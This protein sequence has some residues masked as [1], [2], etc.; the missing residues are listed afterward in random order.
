MRN[1][2]TFLK[3]YPLVVVG[4][5]SCWLL[6]GDA[7]SALAAC[8]GKGV[9]CATSSQCCSAPDLACSPISGDCELATYSGICTT[10]ADCVSS[11]CGASGQCLPNSSANGPCVSDLDCG[12]DNLYQLACT[13][14]S[15]LYP[16]GGH[17]CTNDNNCLSNDCVTGVPNTCSC[18]A[19]GTFC[20]SSAN[21]CS[22]ECAGGKCLL[23]SGATCAGGPDCASGTCGGTCACSNLGQACG[24]NGDCATCTANSECVHGV[25]ALKQGTTGCAGKLCVGDLPSLAAGTTCVGGQCSAA[26]SVFNW[27]D[28]NTDCGTNQS[29]YTLENLGWRDG[30]CLITTAQA[31]ANAVSSD[32]CLSNN[33]AGTPSKCTCNGLYGPCVS[34]TD[35]CAASNVGCDLATNQCLLQKSKACTQNFQCLSDSCVTSA[36]ACSAAGAECSQAADCCSGGPCNAGHC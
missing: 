23:A 36:C 14:S 5:A 32:T 3:R 12:L 30:Y 29:C 13:L 10:N 9:A 18:S 6:M 35:C 33:C 20:D 19:L 25:C 27:C 31:C 16:T 34:N 28:S 15:C 24:G 8:V 21:C 26:A 22:G 11:N 7:G 4:A 17:P 2:V 1:L